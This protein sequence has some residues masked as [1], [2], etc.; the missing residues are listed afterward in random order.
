VAGG[1]ENWFI[2]RELPGAISS[3]R[4]LRRLI[5][6][7]RALALSNRLKGSISGL[8]GNIGFGLL[9]GFM[10]VLFGLFGIPLEVR[11]VTFVSGQLVFSVLAVPSRAERGQL[12]GVVPD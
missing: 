12:R 9:L 4:V 1:V 10:P 2:V 5:G 3:N 6:P 7:A 8:G 11:H